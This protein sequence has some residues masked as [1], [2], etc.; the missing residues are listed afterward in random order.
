MQDTQK[1]K[2]LEYQK[3][4]DAFYQKFKVEFPEVCK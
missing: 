2:F 3:K 1:V 4:A